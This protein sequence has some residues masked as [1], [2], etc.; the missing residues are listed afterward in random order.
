MERADIQQ[1]TPSPTLFL[2][3]S[4]EI[5]EIGMLLSDPSCRLL[6]LVGPGGIGKTRLAMEVASH[7]RALFPD[8]VFRASLA[9]LSWTND[10]LPT[11][12]EAMPFRFQQNQR[13]P[14]EQFFAYLHDK[15]EQR[16]LLVLD[17]LEHLLDGTDLIADILEA[18]SGLKILA[19]SREAL[20]LQE[21]WVRPITGLS[22]PDLED[23]KAATDYSAVQLFLE[24][25]RRIRGDFDL[26]EDEQGV[27]EICQLVEGMPLAIE[28]AAG[29]L[30]TLQPSDI[31]H[32]IKHNLDLL[33]TRARNLPERHRSMRSVFDHSW[34]LM[35]EQD[36]VVFQKLSVFRGG[37]T[38]EA[39]EVVAGA[40]LPALARL[41]D[42]SLLRRSATG[43]YEIHELLRQYGAEQLAAIGQTEAVEQAYINYYLGLLRRLERDIK[44]HN[45]IAALDTIATDF[46]NVRHAWHLAVHQRQVTGLSS[47]VETLHWF[48]DM[49]GHYHEIVAMLQFAVEQFSTSPT[50]EQQLILNRIQARLLRLI[51]LGSLRI[52]QDLHTQ[53]DHCLDAARTQEDQAEIGFCLLVS[54]ILA[55]WDAGGKAPLPSRAATD[56][57]ESAAIFERLGDPF[58]QAEALSWLAGEVPLTNGTQQHSE[59]ELFKQSLDLRRAIGDRNGIAW[60]I[61]NLTCTTLAQQDYL[62]YERSTREALAAMHEIRSV[63]GIVQALFN[64]AQATFWKGEVEEALALAEQMS[65]QA[66]ETSYL[67]GARLSADLQVF[68][69][70]VLHESY[71]DSAELL[72]TNWS[73]SPEMFFSSQYNLGKHWGLALAHCGLGQYAAARAGYAALFQGSYDDPA[74]ATLC[75]ALEAIA[76]ADEDAPERAAELLGLAFEQLVQVSGW[77]ERW[78][79]VPQLCTN[80]S[81]RLGE[82]AYQSARKRGPRW[83]WK[84]RF[85]LS[86]VKRQR[87]PAST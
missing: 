53:I 70:C 82:E 52:E 44:A 83:I 2:G 45:Q 18:T 49:R 43:H 8:G 28:L 26:A 71:A 77:L 60:S 21:E 19:T 23:G 7:H 46:E 47:A 24:R 67:D 27:I 42:Q 9:Q 66:H 56:F 29:W 13:S 6:T 75:L 84:P 32:E 78:A 68:L 1:L 64:L 65:K 34:Q 37:F 62:T 36:R 59:Q 86:W 12:A 16:V 63:K 31:A 85:A 10:L 74:P 80:L 22:Y 39:A 35:S 76:C 73:L 25:A 14:R 30:K 20:N 72:R 51:L 54:G 58:Y 33:A 81:E 38:R 79:K 3:R 5:A 40:S 41:I 69:R 57:E 50:P 87:H 4:Q 48:A 11:I 61:F 15:Q 17:N 55:I